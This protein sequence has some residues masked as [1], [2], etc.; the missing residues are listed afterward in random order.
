MLAKC[1]KFIVFILVFLLS[2]CGGETA[3]VRYKLIAKANI[4]GEIIESYAVNELTMSI[5]S[6][7][8]S[9]NAASASLTAEATILDMGERGSVYI[10]QNVNNHPSA[11]L[12]AYDIAG[13]PGSLNEERIRKMQLVQTQGREAWP[14]K[15]I[16]PKM[17]AFKDE[18]DPA[19]IFEVTRKNFSQHFGADAKFIG[20]YIEPTNEAVSNEIPKNLPWWRDGK[21][22][23]VKKE[24][25]G[26]GLNLPLSN[27]ISHWQFKN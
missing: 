25:G 10:L 7:S 14:R 27:T 17:V 22:A 6:L 20:L 1:T 11:I 3:T 16:T 4:G 26:S 5:S 24:H 12:I 23:L 2:G 13:S 9:G 18:N 8:L 19:T 21:G 15:L